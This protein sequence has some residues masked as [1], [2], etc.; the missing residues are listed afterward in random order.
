MGH[1]KKKTKNEND[2]GGGQGAQSVQKRSQHGA[3]LVPNWSQNGPKMRSLAT[4]NLDNCKGGPTKIDVRSP[5]AEP[6]AKVGHQSAT[7]GDKKK[8]FKQK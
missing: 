5:S 4:Q 6:V 2:P 8:K 1:S 3:I 7:W